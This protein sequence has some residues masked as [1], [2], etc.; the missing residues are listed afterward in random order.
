MLQ[1]NVKGTA[2]NAE[3]I[4]AQGLKVRDD[5][6]AFPPLFLLLDVDD[7]VWDREV[8]SETPFVACAEAGG[9]GMYQVFVDVGRL[10]CWHGCKKFRRLPGGKRPGEVLA[11]AENAQ[12][13]QFMVSVVKNNLVAQ[14]FLELP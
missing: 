12:L 5:G 13:L 4:A 14:E 8:F 6:A 2:G 9:D 1:D 10:E 11:G 3:E 7:A